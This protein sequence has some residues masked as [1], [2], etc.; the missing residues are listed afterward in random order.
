MSL[1]ILHNAS[2]AVANRLLASN[3]AQVSRSVAQLS[4][5]TRVLSARDDAAALAIGSRLRAEVASLVQASVNAGQAASMLQIAD[6]AA[7]QIDNILVRMKALAVQAGSDQISNV[8]R[9]ML[10][11]EYQTLA[12]ELDRIARSANFN[13]NNLLE[14]DVEGGIV[15]TVRSGVESGTVKLAGKI[16]GLG[17]SFTEADLIAGRVTY[18]HDGSATTNDRLI[19]SISDSQGKVIGRQ[20]GEL[21]RTQ[22]QTQEYAASTA[23]DNIAASSAYARGATGAGVTVAVIDTGI[24]LDHP[25][26]QTNLVLAVD[27]K[28][29]TVEGLFYSIPGGSFVSAGGGEVNQIDLLAFDPGVDLFTSGIVPTLDITGTAD[30]AVITLNAGG[31]EYRATYN[32]NTGGVAMQLGYTLTEVGGSRTIDIAL[33]SDF[34]AGGIT[35]AGSILVQFDTPTTPDGNDDNLG[36]DAGHGTHVAGIIAAEKN[37]SGTHGV[38]YNA[39]LIAVNIGEDGGGLDQRNLADAIDF[40]VANGA[41]VINLSLGGSSIIAA[42]ESAITRAVN[43]GVIIVASTGNDALDDPA[44]PAAF[45]IDPAARGMLIA[46]TATD[47]ENELASFSNKA[48]LIRDFT[49]AAPGVAIIS[50]TNDGATGSMSGTSMAAP[51]VSGAV[52]LLREKFT[53]LSGHEI[54]NLLF[55]ST[56]DLGLPGTDGTY[57]RGLINLNKATASQIA[58]SFNISAINVVGGAVNVASEATVAIDRGVLRYTDAYV[59]R[60]EVANRSFTYK[61]GTGVSEAD[62][63]SVAIGSLTANSLELDDTSIGTGAGA[64]TASKRVTAALDR[65]VAVRAEIGA[66]QKRLAVATS[67]LAAMT[68]NTE[69]ARSA[70]LDLDIAQGMMQFTSQQILTQ[71]SIGM[72]AQANQQAQLLLRLLG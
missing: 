54:A 59:G 18:T 65:L 53:D 55:T 47:N 15:Y 8:E 60:I 29:D 20:A 44:F 11:T 7:A 5:G 4:A 52:A 51:M 22:F 57:G 33:T 50:T 39:R 40:A 12:S 31:V 64:E 10:D 62:R 30:A 45:A 28:D 41:D 35:S 27:L 67:N 69:V 48:G 19:L 1:S 70:L 38:A 13:G 37:G 14:G 3:D 43:A 68:E 36:P 24:D 66:S 2:A 16:L 72:A 6:G 26:F 34:D 61:V 71:A 23:L 49:V 32:M 46:V 58:L 25:E 42:V 56:D 63:L 21:D 9:G 17:D